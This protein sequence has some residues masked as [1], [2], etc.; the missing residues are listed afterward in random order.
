M[1]LTPDVLVA[2]TGCRP[3]IANVFAPH[4]A[5]AMADFDISTPLRQAH[6]I[7]QCA[8]E[9]VLFGVLEENLNYSAD[10]LTAIFSKYFANPPTIPAGKF[11]ANR[12]GRTTTHGANLEGIANIIYANRMGNGP[13]ETGDGWKY[14]GRGMIQLT[15]RS[16]YQAFVDAVGK[17]PAISSPDVLTLDEPAATS[18]AWF[19]AAH[20]CNALADADD[21]DAVTMKINGGVLG[22]AAREGL[23]QRAKAALGA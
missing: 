9:S 15:G 11:D 1:T 3:V 17:F 19:W 18:A 16:M 12:Y 2:A 7:A 5:R 6:F 21:V 8:H 23:T 22:I 4:L 14:R 13:T 10:A 20:G